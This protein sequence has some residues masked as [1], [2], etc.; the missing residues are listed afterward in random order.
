MASTSEK[1]RQKSADVVQL[2]SDLDLRFLNRSGP[3]VRGS[4]HITKKSFDPFKP[5]FYIVKLGFT[6]FFLFLLKNI[7][8]GYSLELPR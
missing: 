4:I 1:Q 7:D 8:S 5:H 2:Q 3:L 6:L